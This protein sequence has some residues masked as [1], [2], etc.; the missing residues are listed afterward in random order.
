[1]YACTLE[2]TLAPL[3]GAIGAAGGVLLGWALVRAYA[4]AVPWAV[5]CGGVAYAVAVCFHG[6]GVNGTAPLVAIGLLLS[7]E[8]ATWSIAERHRIAVD[9]A[10][11]LGRASAVAA[12]ALGGL[13]AAALVVGLAAA[14]GVAGLGWTLIGAA[15]AVLAV[16]VVTRLAARR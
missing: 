8:L 7:A 10:V 3:V 12:L 15:A 13:V 16:T 14:P 2:P 9:R 11:V 6:S 1:V 4:D 5:L